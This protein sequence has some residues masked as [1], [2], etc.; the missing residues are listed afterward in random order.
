MPD[1]LVVVVPAA[2][3]L[4]TFETQSDGLDVGAP[5]RGD[6]DSSTG[7]RTRRIRHSY[8]SLILL[9]SLCHSLTTALVL[10]YRMS[11]EGGGRWCPFS[12]AGPIVAGY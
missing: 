6:G 4:P 2:G 1:D 8:R 10:A 9:Q 3:V 5:H 11:S 7:E 12:V